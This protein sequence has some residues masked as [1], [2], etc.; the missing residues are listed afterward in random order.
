MRLTYSWWPSTRQCGRCR[1]FHVEYRT[2]IWR[3][4]EGIHRADVYRCVDCGFQWETCDD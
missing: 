4:D 3:N 2:D 1:G